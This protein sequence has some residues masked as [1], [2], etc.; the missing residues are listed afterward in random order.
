MDILGIL[1][2]VGFMVLRAMAE[3]KRKQERTQRPPGG[4]RPSPARPPVETRPRS[5]RPLWPQA[6]TGPFGGPMAPRPGRPVPPFFPI[7]LPWEGEDDEELFEEERRETFPEQRR[8]P[9]PSTP[10]GGYLSREGVGIEGTSKTA[11]G[12]RQEGGTPG[13]GEGTEGRGVMEGAEAPERKLPRPKQ[14]KRLEPAVSLALPGFTGDD[15]LR[16]IVMAELLQPPRSRRP[17]PHRTGYQVEH[18]EK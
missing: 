8:Q 15:V 1:I 6:P 13:Q 5:P 12:C 10:D 9:G 17:G 16:G 3:A 4:A 11:E 14:P 18:R 2:F 7:P